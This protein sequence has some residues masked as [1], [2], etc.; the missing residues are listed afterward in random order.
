MD[1]LEEARRLSVPT[2]IG[3]F[4]FVAPYKKQRLAAEGYARQLTL[5]QPVDLQVEAEARA[6]AYC[7]TLAVETPEGFNWNTF[8]D[9]ELLVELYTKL[10]EHDRTF[11]EK[12][13]GT[14]PTVGA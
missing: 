6:L 10:V 9:D 7:E 5:G 14:G 8:D 4:V 12:F 3:T 13:Q 2:K 1:R 11:R